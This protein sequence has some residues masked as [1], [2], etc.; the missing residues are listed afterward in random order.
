[1]LIKK[2]EYERDLNR[3]PRPDNGEYV[4]EIT[5][6]KFVP[7]KNPK[8]DD[9]IRIVCR[10][11]EDQFLGSYASGKCSA[12]VRPDNRTE[13]WFKGFGVTLDVGQNIDSDQLIGRKARIVVETTEDGFTNIKEVYNMRPQDFTRISARLAN[14]SMIRNAPQAAAPTVIQSSQ[15][16]PV[17]VSAPAATTPA[18]APQASTPSISA[19]P[20]ADDD[21]PF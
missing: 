17:Q 4:A 13:K 3:F 6:V 1:M 15:P 10:I 18:P 12:I 20:I 21:L 11:L 5:N 9:G 14:Q 19:A 16:A 7:K 2:E 8:W